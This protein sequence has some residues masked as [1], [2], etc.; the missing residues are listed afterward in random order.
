MGDHL[1]VDILRVVGRLGAILVVEMHLEQELQA[2][3]LAMVMHLDP[4]LLASEVLDQD[5]PQVGLVPSVE[6]LVLEMHLVDPLAQAAG[7]AAQVLDLEVVEMGEAQ[8]AQE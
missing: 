7:V 8:P 5:P 4:D 3:V 2:L 6:T 1:E